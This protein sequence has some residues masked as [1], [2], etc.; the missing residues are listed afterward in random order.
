M[1]IPKQSESLNLHFQQKRKI[2]QLTNKVE[3]QQE[4]SLPK[5]CPPVIPLLSQTPLW[6]TVKII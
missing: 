6:W 5:I 3:L 4:N 1:E 2:F